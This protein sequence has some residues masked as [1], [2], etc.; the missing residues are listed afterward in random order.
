ML[1]H[2]MSQSVLFVSFVSS[3]D[4]L[5]CTLTCQQKPNYRRQWKEVASPILPLFALHHDA[6]NT[7][8][9]HKP[10]TMADEDVDKA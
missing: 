7:E 1:M 4:K 8:K 10:E 2:K 5:H 9:V 6:I 3:D